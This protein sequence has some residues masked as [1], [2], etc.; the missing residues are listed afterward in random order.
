MPSPT[1]QGVIPA[2]LTPRRADSVTIDTSA[3]LELIEFLES[4]HVDG[5]CLLGSTGE[6]PHFAPDDRIRFAEMAIRRARVPVLVNVSHSTL[7]GSIEIGQAAAASGAAGVLLMPPYYYRYTQESIR[8]FALEFAAEVDAPVYL[9]NIGQFTTELKLETSLALLDTGKF[10]GI[11][12]SYGGWED[13]LALQK[14]GCTIFTGADTM[15]GKVARAGGAGTVSGTASILPDLLVALDRGARAGQDTAQ[16]E[17][18]VEQFLTRAMSFP[19]PSAF[20]EAALI[21]GLKTGPHA[22]PLGPEEGARMEEFREW[23]R[24]WLKEL[25]PLH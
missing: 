13:F 22:A 15:Y 18:L 2:A 11:K 20:R 25:P 21:R 7:D 12:D 3:A 23:F 24:A 8:A 19:F 4:H 17:S 5:I 16:I 6:F 1:L 14:T 9:Y 10:A